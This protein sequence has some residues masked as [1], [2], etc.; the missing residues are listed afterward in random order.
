MN[1]LHDQLANSITE[2]II[3]NTYKNIRMYGYLL[4]L[5]QKEFVGNDHPVKTAGIGLINDKYKLFIN[6]DFWNDPV[7]MN[8]QKRVF[9][10]CHEVLHT[11]YN[12]PLYDKSVDRALFNESTDLYI[13]SILL[14]DIGINSIPGCDSTKDWENIH[15]PALESLIDD[16]EH[17]FIDEDE[18]KKRN[19]QIPIRGIHPDDYDDPDITMEN[20]INKGSFW[21]YEK[22]FKYKEEQRCQSKSTD[23]SEID[24]PN[25]SRSNSETNT[26]QSNT[27]NDSQDPQSSQDIPDK[28]N[29]L[30]NKEKNQSQN[31][32]LNTY[33][34]NDLPHPVNHNEWDDI[35]NLSEGVKKFIQDQEEYLI[36]E[37]LNEL[38]K[39]QGNIPGYLKELLKKI[40]NPGKPVFDYVGFIR[41]WIG[42]FG[43]F[44]EITR[45]RSKP[46]LIV[47]DAQRLKF[48]YSKHLFVCIDTSA[49]MGHDDLNEV[50]TELAKIQK[51]TKMKITLCEVD[52]KIHN[53]IPI[54]SLTDINNYISKRGIS[55][56]GGTDFSPITKHLEETKEKYSGV[57]YLTDGFL[58]KP[59]KYP[60]IPL[61]VVITSKGVKV[62]WDNIKVIQIPVDRLNKN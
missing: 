41:K 45:S 32:S 36:K 37:T 23:Q 15:K 8:G 14:R 5:L 16:Y 54:E 33:I 60:K 59:K 20:C 6:E 56:R 1:N 52:A 7:N 40:N 27:S 4:S 47:E 9:L 42:A 61:L 48:T 58:S 35:N 39:Q 11:M 25:G 34:N 44:N 26:D 19:S 50:I 22:L 10:L 21:I 55:G 62:N 24:Y 3:G 53:L 57:I 17:G 13:N 51:V 49:S 12:H 28:G 46:S 30:N 31:E 38:E 18:F 29:D 2:I 43:N